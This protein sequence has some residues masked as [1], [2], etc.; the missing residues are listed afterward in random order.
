MNRCRTCKFWSLWPSKPD[1]TNSVQVGQ[2]GV[3]H[4]FPPIVPHGATKTMGG[5]YAATHEENWCGEHRQAIDASD[6]RPHNPEL[7][8]TD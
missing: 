7:Y 2:V 5:I 6:Q 3:C 8:E 1:T 4:R